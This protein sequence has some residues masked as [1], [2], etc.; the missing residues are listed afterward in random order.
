[1]LVIEDDRVSQS[2]I[3]LMLERFGVTS[4]IVDNGAAGIEAVTRGSWDA[5]LM[6]GQLP[7]MDGYETTRRM[8]GVLAG[9]RLPIIALT[10][11]VMVGNRQMSRD[12]GMDDFLAKPIRL[13]ELHACLKK[14]LPPHGGS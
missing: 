9:R 12:A 13:D 11:N 6:D 2:V 5:V 14:W 10:A 8:R 1:M 7:G 3:R 4:E